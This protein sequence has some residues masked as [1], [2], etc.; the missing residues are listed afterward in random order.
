[1]DPNGDLPDFRVQDWLYFE[2]MW[3]RTDANRWEGTVW[4]LSRD[5]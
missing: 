4:V 3:D 1:L 2:D 5:L